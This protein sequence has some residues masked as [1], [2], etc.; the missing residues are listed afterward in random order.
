MPNEQFYDEGAEDE[1]DRGRIKGVD[2][3]QEIAKLEKP[4]RDRESE[5]RR[6]TETG[7][8]QEQRDN[9]Q[10]MKGLKEK[11]PDAF[12]SVIDDKGR[13]AMFLSEPFNVKR[14][15]SDQNLVLTQNGIVYLLG[16]AVNLRNIDFTKFTD[17]VGSE[18]DGLKNSRRAHKKYS[19]IR[20]KNVQFFDEGSLDAGV[21]IARVELEHPLVCE[22]L[23]T[24]FQAVQKDSVRYKGAN[25]E[26]KRAKTPDEVLKNL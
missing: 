15:G 7:L 5:L 18:S 22:N 25:K 19:E 9:L 8:T 13:E 10:I 3:A 16:T 20:K 26:V 23:R 24:V 14:L 1:R 2:K 17:W 4:A 11:Y 12:E 6:Q 21:S